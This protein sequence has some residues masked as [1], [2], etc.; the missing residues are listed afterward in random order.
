MDPVSGKLCRYPAADDIR[1]VHPGWY[2][3]SHT[4]YWDKREFQNGVRALLEESPAQVR[5]ARTDFI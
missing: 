2:F 5:S 3:V 1:I 4:K